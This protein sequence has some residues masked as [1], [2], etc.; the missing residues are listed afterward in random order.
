MEKDFSEYWNKRYVTDFCDVDV[1]PSEFVK[2]TVERIKEKGDLRILDLGCGAGRDTLYFANLG[3]K[4]TALDLSSKALSL[5]Q[6]KPKNVEFICE[7]MQNIN[8]PANSFD[9]V[10]ANLTLH[11]FDDKTT[12]K[13]IDNITKSLV[14][15]GVL[16]FLCKSTKDP[17]W[18]V[19]VKVEEN[20]YDDKYRHH[21]FDKKY[22]NELLKDYNINPTE[23]YEGF[24]YKP[25]AFIEV[26]AVKK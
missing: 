7:D 13:I 6:K 9:V 15:D 10:F 18:G 17:L 12:R 5:F 4:V 11:Y 2:R 26:L 23:E 14:K 3:Y 19:G 20:V 24:Y 22:I 1:I 16:T 25:C 21:F 8:L